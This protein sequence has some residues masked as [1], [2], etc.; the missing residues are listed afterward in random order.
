MGKKHNYNLY[1]RLVYILLPNEKNLI[2][3]QFS[4]ETKFEN[5]F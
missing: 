5:V 3:I 2:N 1:Y 4:V